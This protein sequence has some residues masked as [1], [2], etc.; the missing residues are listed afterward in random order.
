MVN[1]AKYF[2]DV[3]T[4]RLQEFKKLFEKLEK[5]WQVIEVL[6]KNSKGFKSKRLKSLITVNDGS[7]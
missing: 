1:K 5:S 3:S 4:N 2:I 6:R 7:E